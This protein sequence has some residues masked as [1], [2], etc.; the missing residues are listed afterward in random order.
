MK[1]FSI[2]HSVFRLMLMAFVGIALFSCKNEPAYYVSDLQAYWQENN[3][4]HFIRFTGEAANRTGYMWG[5]EWNAKEY[6]EDDLFDP[7][8]YHGTGWFEYQ[9]EKKGDLHEIHKMSN[10][11][12]DI[13]KEYVISR[14][15]T[16]ALEYYESGNKKNK[17]YFTKIKQ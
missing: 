15:T 11:G 13:P 5:Y 3:T 7:S 1:A 12:A 9:M 8:M 2:Q 17:Y 10:G 6:T 4:Q 16:S 14:L